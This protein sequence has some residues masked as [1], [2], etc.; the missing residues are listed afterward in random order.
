MKKLISIFAVFCSTLAFSQS[1]KN[2]IKLNLLNSIIGAPEIT[3]EKL[4]KKKQTE[5][6]FAA[7]KLNSK[8]NH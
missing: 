8:E 4:N 2:E 7:D 6:I 1:Q 3:Y 5:G